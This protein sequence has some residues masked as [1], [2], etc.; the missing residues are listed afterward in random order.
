V[1]VTTIKK[2][3]PFHK[4]FET[5]PQPLFKG[6]SF[7]EDMDIA[8][9]CFRH[10]EKIF[11]QLD[12]FR[13][14]ELL[15]RGGD[16]TNYLLVK[17]AKIIAMTCTHA[18]LKRKDMVELNFQFDNVLMEEAAQILEIETFIPLM[19]QK[20]QDGVS[21]LKRMTLIGDHHQLPPVIKNMAFQK[22][23]NMEQS[24]FTRFVRL[25]VPTVDL[26][27]QGRSRARY[28]SHDLSTCPVLIFYC[29]LV[30][31]DCTVGDIRSWAV[32]LTSIA[33]QSIR[34][35]TLVS[36]MITSSLM[37]RI[38]MDMERLNQLHTSI[39]IWVKL[40]MWW[41]STCT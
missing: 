29:C 20:P 26:D 32:Y 3:F 14:F 34:W 30:S 15:R 39:R 17:E 24:L 25:G 23:C 38:S 12:E 31:V 10:I 1:D 8:E 27:A 35:P 22:F 40:S 28:N 41:L 9:G 6:Q 33:G 37:W 16:R 21:R 36:S 5:A 19:L 18:A 4:Y 13:G 2:E 11:T 7:E